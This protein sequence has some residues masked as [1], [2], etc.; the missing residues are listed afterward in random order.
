LTPRRRERTVDTS[1]AVFARSRE[2]VVMFIQL[3]EARTNDAEAVQRQMQ[4]WERELM[5][6]AIGYLGST[7]GCTAA[8]DCVMVARFTDA[9]SARR[10][11]DRPEQGDWW[12][13]TEAC[14]DGPVRFRE[15]TDVDIMTHGD[16]DRARFVQVMDGRV[17]DKPRSKQLAV[18]ADPI[19]AELRPELLGAVTAYF[20]GDEFVELAYFTDEAAARAGETQELPPDAAELIAEWQQVFA[21]ERYRDLTDPWLTSNS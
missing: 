6:G 8:G 15:T 5:P 21:I 13:E 20:E 9:D 10:N 17:A 2:E 4:R 12:K 1:G 3:M 7:G 11:S 19:L 14:F 18:D 16:L